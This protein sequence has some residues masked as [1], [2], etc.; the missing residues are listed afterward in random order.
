MKHIILTLALI[1]LCSRTLVAQ[2]APFDNPRLTRQNYSSGVQKG[3]GESAPF[4]IYK[5]PGK[6]ASQY[7]PQDWR[8][9]IDSTWGPGA[10]LVTKLA[11][12]DAYASSLTN[13][14]DGFLSLGLTWS[15]WDSLKNAFRSRI[16]ATTSRGVFASIMSQFAMSLRDGHT[17][18]W[19]TGVLYAPLLP[20]VP[21][22][23]LYPFEQADHFGAVLTALPDSTALVLRTVPNHPLGLQPGDVVLGYESVPWKQ[24]VREL[25]DA[26]LP[27]F[28]T[29]VGAASA[30]IHSF[31]R[32]VGNNWHLFDTIDILK[33]ST[34]DTLHLSVLPL[35]GLPTDPMTGNE[36]LEI[37]GIPMSFYRGW[38]WVPTGQLL[39]Y[40]KL[41][42]AN[43]GYIR[44]LGEWPSNAADPLFA[45]AVDSLWNAEGLIIDLRYNS[46]GWS[47]FNAAFSRMFSERLFT[48]EDVRRA[49]TTTFDLVPYGNAAEGLIPGTPGS[50]YDR[51]IAVLLGP[52]C[53]SLGDWT[54]QRLRYHPMTRFFGKPSFASIGYSQNVT[55]WSNWWLRHSITDLY[56]ISQPGVYLNRQEFPVDEPVWFN[57]DDVANGIDRVVKNA[58]EWID[59]VAYAHDVTVDKPYYVLGIDTITARA[60]VENPNGH[61]LNILAYCKADDVI[62]DSAFFYDDGLHH[63]SLPGDG[64]WGAL[65]I[66]PAL[67]DTFSIAISTFDPVDTSR[68]TLQ[69]LCSFTTAGPARQPA[70]SISHDTLAVDSVV[71]GHVT[72][73]SVTVSNTGTVPLSIWSVVSDNVEFRVTPTGGTIAPSA[74]KTFTIECTAPSYVVTNGHI[75]FTHNAP[76]PSDTLNIRAD[77]RLAFA[78][79]DRW[80]LISVPVVT[81]DFR[82]HILFPSS[83]SSAWGYNGTYIANDSMMNGIGYWLRFSGAQI[84][85]LAGSPMTLD[86]ITVTEGWNIVGSIGVP[87]AVTNITSLPLGLVTSKFYGFRGAYQTV[88]SI[89]PGHGYWVKA[90]Q[91][92]LLILSFSGAIPA[93]NRIRIEQTS[94]LPPPPPDGLE[95][96]MDARKPSQ[97]SLGQNYPNPFN[98]ATVIRYSLPVSGHVTLKLYNLLGQEVVLLVDEVQEAGYKSVKLDGS[99]LSSGVYFYRLVTGSYIETRKMVLMR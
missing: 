30:E 91:A 73:D 57:P 1:L 20:G 83:V 23:D 77:A 72:Y 99:K 17:W 64:V 71:P 40:G 54:A 4:N 35:L 37:P 60:R 13:Q 9:V 45:A 41:P 50:I 24:L 6:R 26:Q 25:L 51:P 80:N 28:S 7:S 76:G 29:G 27:V 3:R 87:V 93:E 98:P 58:V 10:P 70:F 89:E 85:R 82:R 22:L 92:G 21:I 68:F 69:Q 31:I 2:D 49:N 96:E 97:Y 81:D 78:V 46:G 90:N 84:L 33:Q 12:F 11:I 56:H 53:M 66:A 88:D 14:F 74:S 39:A 18:A 61:P 59:S 65:W 94:E 48:T 38:P 5:I 15:S 79:Q 47:Q 8:H 86:S 55:G 43:I 52:T 16:D 75:I 36:Q 44:L 63:D 19:D 67:E 32:N 95:T 62:V 42:G 34:H